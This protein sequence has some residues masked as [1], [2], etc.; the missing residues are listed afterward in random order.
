MHETGGDETEPLV[1]CRTE[2]PR[3]VIAAACVRA[4][5]LG[6]RP[7]MAVAQAQAMQPGLRVVRET[8]EQDQ[9][10]LNKVAAWCLRYTPLTRAV[11][12]DGVWL[13]LTG[14]A[15][16][17][18][19][20]SALLSDLAARLSR[21]GL[22]NR[23]ALA[24]TPGAAHALAHYGAQPLTIAPPGDQQAL[25]A[26]PVAA[27]RIGDEAA[28]LLRRL[29]L[30]RIGD[31]A[32]LPRA[33]LARR[34][35]TA[36]TLRLDQA[37]GRVDEPI[38]PQASPA[39]IAHRLCFV[40]PLLTADAL[41]AGIRMLAAALCPLLEARGLGARRLALCF[42]RVDNSRQVQLV[43]LAG[44]SRDGRHIARLFEERLEQVDPGDGIEA[45]A[46]SA[47]IAETLTSDQQ[48]EP[49]V[50][51]LIDRLANRLGTNRLWRP[52]PVQS[53]VPERAVRPVA[54]IQTQRTD[55]T[56]A[57][58]PSLPRPIRLFDPPVPVQT[59]TALPDQPPSFFIWRRHRHQVR[60][61]DGPERIAGEW[62]RRPGELLAVRD[63][64]RLEDET[65]RRFWLFRRG[66]GE[67]AQTGDLSW[68]L[69]GLF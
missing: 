66:D 53:D 49:D 64:F 31:L 20:E 13:D 7:G 28:A 30:R 26:L 38:T 50:A 59:L 27:L 21:A 42:E 35:G 52:A 29:G 15:H 55:C 2:G 51:P 39:E 68:F 25:L 9:A 40:E 58:P 37:L 54:P 19:G 17:H 10:A 44:A 36:V 43:S 33:P 67:D 8:P 56:L 60:R 48:G 34:L 4:T 12:P 41:A 65:G 47:A 18:G 69:H 32:A 11:P 3:L 14:C 63:Y 5:R 45:I 22:H 16:L 62:W 1:I 46:L 23:I 6:L 57:W 24:D 61:A